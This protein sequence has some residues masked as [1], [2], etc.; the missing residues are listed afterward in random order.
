MFSDLSNM[1]V[2]VKRSNFLVS[3]IKAENVVKVGQREVTHLTRAVCS[4]ATDWESKKALDLDPDHQN[5]FAT[6]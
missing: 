2:S 1:R 3:L 5:H 4:E 6:Y